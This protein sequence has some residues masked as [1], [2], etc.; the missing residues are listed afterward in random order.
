MR[1]GVSDLIDKTLEA[2]ERR[3]YTVSV[4]PAKT[5]VIQNFRESVLLFPQED[6][7]VIYEV[8]EPLLPVSK[9]GHTESELELF[10]MVKELR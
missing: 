1:S 8:R 6:G 9:R 4:H 7:S 10:K 2:A 5:A 3:G